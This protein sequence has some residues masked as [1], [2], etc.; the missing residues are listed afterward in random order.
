MAD[1][2]TLKN[3]RKRS[4]GAFTEVAVTTGMLAFVAYFL[5]SIQDLR[6]Q[7]RVFPTAVLSACA[8]LLLITLISA[9]VKLVR[10]DTTDR[11]TAEEQD[12]ELGPLYKS[13]LV[14]VVLVGAAFAINHLGFY[15]AVPIV[16]AL[17]FWVAG[18]RP[19]WL[20][21]LLSL[22]TTG[23]VWLIFDQLV[24]VTLPR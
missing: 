21:V 4:I 13:F 5:F 16:A 18:C 9:A 20:A 6:F 14:P 17:L 22:P 23:L 11:S 24:G 7:A 10:A 1:S 3:V 8:V 2:R 12:V 15:V 19:W